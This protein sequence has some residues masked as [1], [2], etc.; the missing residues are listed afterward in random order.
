MTQWFPTEQNL[1]FLMEKIKEE[2]KHKKIK[3]L[4]IDANAKRS[5]EQ[6]DR[7]WALYKSVGDHLGY[8]QDEM[9]QILK[10][11]FLRVQKEV[12]EEI[13]ESTKS[14]TKLSVKEMGDYQSAIEVWAS[15][16]GWSWNE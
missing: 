3:V 1:P 8:T 2:M 11:K 4:I 15:Q 6:N 14:T 10:F 9:H 13:V 5:H 16:L 12:N 7:L